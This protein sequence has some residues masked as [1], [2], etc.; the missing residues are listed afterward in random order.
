MYK[1]AQAIAVNINVTS[2][3]IWGSQWD[4]TMRCLY[5]IGN[6]DKTHFTYDSRGKGNY[7][8]D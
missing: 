2:S 6:E 3:M 1:K 7:S 8:S 5:T 4:A